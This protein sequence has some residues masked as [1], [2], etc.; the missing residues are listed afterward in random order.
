MLR[1]WTEKH[2]SPSLATTEPVVSQKNKQTGGQYFQR[3]GK[4]CFT[5][6]NSLPR[7]EMWVPHQGWWKEHAGLKRRPHQSDPASKPFLQLSKCLLRMMTDSDH[8]RDW[9]QPL[10]NMS[11][12]IWRWNSP[13][14]PALST[15]LLL[16]KTWGRIKI[17]QVQMPLGGSK[18]MQSHWQ[19]FG[20]E[21]QEGGDPRLSLGIGV[22]F[23]RMEQRIHPQNLQIHQTS[24]GWSPL[25]FPKALQYNEIISSSRPPRDLFGTM[26][27]EAATNHLNKVWHH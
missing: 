10:G 15:A 24:L 3:G 26:P 7:G 8:Y 20:R 18:A 6:R 11:L 25:S 14:P 19:G 27:R 21:E 1:K 13:T 5:F 17:N 2:L 16:L 12:L 22:K 9:P 4:D 23:A